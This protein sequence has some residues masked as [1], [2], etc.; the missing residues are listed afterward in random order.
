MNQAKKRQ[1]IYMVVYD[2]NVEDKFKIEPIEFRSLSWKHPLV[3]K[4]GAIFADEAYAKQ[5]LEF[6][7]KNKKIVD[8]QTKE[9]FLKEVEALKQKE[10]A[11]EPVK[12]EEDK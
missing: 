1:L 3:K 6:V 12:N 7:I 8:E 11:T 5:F 2:A 4:A 9:Q 10:N